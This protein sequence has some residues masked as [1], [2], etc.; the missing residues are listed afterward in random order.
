MPARTQPIDEASILNRITD[1]VGALEE[2]VKRRCL[3]PGYEFDF[4]PTGQLLV[5]R[6]SDDATQVIAF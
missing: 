4:T 5:I 2:T 1:R 3:P 6:I